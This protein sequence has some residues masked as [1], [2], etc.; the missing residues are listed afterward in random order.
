MQINSE[1][2]ACQWYPSFH[3]QDLK[4]VISIHMYPNVLCGVEHELSGSTIQWGTYRYADTCR[5]LAG[6]VKMRFWRW[7]MYL[8]NVCV[9]QWPQSLFCDKLQTIKGLCQQST[10]SS[11]SSWHKFFLRLL[12]I[13][14]KWPPSLLVLQLHAQHVLAMYIRGQS[15]S[16]HCLHQVIYSSHLNLLKSRLSYV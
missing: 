16:L 4:P 6:D 11:S 3:Y 2:N 12:P 7:A 8:S 10:C 9:V 13:A 5:Q 14:E 15:G 1:I